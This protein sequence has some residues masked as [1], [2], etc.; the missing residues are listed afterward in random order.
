MHLNINFSNNYLPQNNFYMW[1]NENWKNE[2]ELPKEHERWGSFDILHKKNNLKIKKLL[3]EPNEKYVKCQLLYK[4]GI[5]R[6]NNS[7]IY[8]Y[9]EDI[10]KCN[11]KEHRILNT[12]EPRQ[13]YT[14]TNSIHGDWSVRYSN[15]SWKG[16][17]TLYFGHFVKFC[18]IP[19]PI[20]YTMDIS[21][22][23]YVRMHMNTECIIVRESED[24]F[25]L[26]Y[27]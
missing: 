12:I 20:Y 11:N 25:S 23:T 9:L 17:F 6:S 18:R 4:Q 24:V 22:Y 27:K 2:N 7:E 13:T 1:V 16:G 26:Q 10:D 19:D 8:E 14:S 5:K 21:D 3:E 15:N